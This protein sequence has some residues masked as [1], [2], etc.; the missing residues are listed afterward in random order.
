[1]HHCGSWGNG[2]AQIVPA[3]YLNKFH[4]CS[5][6]LVIEGIAMRFLNDDLG[7]HSGQIRYL[8]DESF[9]VASEN[10]GEARLHRR[11]GAGG[12]QSGVSLGQFEHFSNS[13]PSC[14]FQV[15]H[16]DKMTPCLGHDGFQFGANHRATEH[17]HGSLTVDDGR[18]S[19]FFVRIT[20]LSKAANPGAGFPGK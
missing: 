1:M 14:N 15:R 12:N 7:L 20:R 6:E 18:D 16:P 13:L 9:I 17:R 3:F 19:Q 8:P 10:A 4:P 11:S 5:A 2:L